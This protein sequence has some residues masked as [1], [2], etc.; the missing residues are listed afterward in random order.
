M[1]MPSTKTGMS[2]CL[3]R[4][5]WQVAIALL[6]LLTSCVDFPQRLDESVRHSLG[7]TVIAIADTVPAFNFKRFALSKPAGTLKD[8]IKGMKQSDTLDSAI[9]DLRS[10]SNPLTA[11]IAPY[12]AVADIATGAREGV[13]IGNF[14]AIQVADVVPVY[15]MIQK[16][17]SALYMHKNLALSVAMTARR[18]IGRQ[19]KIID[20]PQTKASYAAQAATGVG[21]V[22]EL[23]VSE[24]GFEGGKP[25]QFYLIAQ[26]RLLRASDIK[27]LYA[28]KFIYVSDPYPVRYWRRDDANLFAAELQRAYASISQ[29]MVEQVYLLTSLPLA[30]HYHG[31][32]M[33]AEKVQRI[34]EACG[35]AWRAPARVYLPSLPDKPRGKNYF[36]PLASRRPELQWEAFP[37]ATDKSNNYAQLLKHITHVRYDLRLWRVEPFMPPELVYQ[38]LGLPQPRHKIELTLAPRAQY[39]LSARARFD[40]AG[41][42]R[43]TRWSAYH[44]P[45]YN[46]RGV[47]QLLPQ[48][49]PSIAVGDLR[50]PCNLDFIPTANYY[51]FQTPR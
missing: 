28:R 43:A 45:Y 42:T 20:M 48:A 9:A 19:L 1:R 51:R 50:D 11:V 32:V 13:A 21:S 31:A 49:T 39:F 2:R 3:P 23:R 5:C 25:L 18:D 35:L 10:A 14:N 46:V 22:L 47:K 33:L 16:R 36:T 4:R 44:I 40:I 17:L 12:L 15:E 34:D 38:R 24:M 30:S 8:N 7:A 6:I 29:S 37:R 26:L 41:Q 27:Q